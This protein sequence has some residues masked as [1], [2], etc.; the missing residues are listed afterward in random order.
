MAAP[1]EAQARTLYDFGFALTGSTVEAEDL[2]LYGFCRADD[3]HPKDERS[4]LMCSMRRVLTEVLN[5]DDQRFISTRPEDALL[6]ELDVM[7]RA[8]VAVRFRLHLNSSERK[9]LLG[10]SPAEELEILIKVA[11]VRNSLM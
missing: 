10:L 3:A 1:I 9:D 2:A 8:L 5:K 6:R 11:E 7:G 4:R